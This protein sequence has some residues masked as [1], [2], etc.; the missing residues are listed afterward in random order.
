M[1]K[2]ILVYGMTDN[3]GG[4]ETYLVNMMQKMRER[5]VIFDYLCDFPTVAHKELIERNGSRIY[6]IPAKSKGLIKHW[7]EVYRVV[8]RHEEYKTIYF[9]ILDAGAAFTMLI[10][11]LMRRKIVVH[12]HNGETDKKRLHKYCRPFMLFMAKEYLAC[13]NV[14]AEFMFGSKHKN[15]VIFIP[16]AI[17]VGK[18]KY[19]EKSRKETREKLNLH[20]DNVVICHVGRLSLQKNPFGMLEIFKAVLRQNDKAILLS[21]GT[22]ELANEVKEKAY[23]LGIHNNVRFLGKRSD[24]AE[25]LQAADVFFLPSFY[26]GLPIVALEAQAAGLPCVLSKNITEEIDLTGNVCFVS[27]SESEERWASILLERAAL[28]RECKG[29]LEETEYNIKNFEQTLNKIEKCL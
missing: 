8:K 18:Y 14:A 29:V 12:S 16:N 3:P 22:G 13:S 27:L 26:E 10:P 9:N 1:A 20:E 11:W 5:D 2:R 17:D 24:V 21:V 6:Y 7:M 23:E 4:I 28:T 15:E 19:N 25:L